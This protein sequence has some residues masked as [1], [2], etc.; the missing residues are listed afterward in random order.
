MAQPRTTTEQ[1]ALLFLQNV[2]PDTGYY[3]YRYTAGSSMCVGWANSIQELYEKMMLVDKGDVYFSTA[4]F[5]DNSSSKQENVLLLKSFRLDI[6]IGKH[7]CY[8]SIREG[9]EALLQFCK[10]INIPFPFLVMSGIGFHAWWALSEPISRERWRTITDRLK[11]ACEAEGLL[12]D[13]VVTKDAARILRC[14]GTFNCKNGKEVELHS[15]YST[16]MKTHKL[17]SFMPLITY[18]LTKEKQEPPQ[19][20][21]VLF[22][23]E[24]HKYYSHLL[25]L[26]PNTIETT[27]DKWFQVAAAVHS[28]GW[29]ET[30]KE[31]FLAWS[32]INPKHEMATFNKTWNGLNNAEYDGK[33]ITPATLTFLAEKETIGTI[34]AFDTDDSVYRMEGYSDEKY[35]KYCKLYNDAIWETTSKGRIKDRSHLNTN[36]AVIGLGIRGKV[37][38]FKDKEELLV[39][40][41]SDEW[42]E[43]SDKLVS[44]INGIIQNRYAFEAGITQTRVALNELCYTFEYNPVREYLDSLVWD[45]VSRLDTWLATW[46]GAE[47]NDLNRFFGSTFLIAAV[48]RAKQPGCKFDHVLVLE[49]STNLGKS[50]SVKILAGHDDYFSD[51]S[52]INKQEREQHELVEGV[53]F[54]EIS[55]LAGLR[56]ADLEALKAF[57]TRTSDKTRKAYAHKK[58]ESSRTC[59]FI[60]TTDNPDPYLQDPSGNRRFW[61]VS[62]KF[63]DIKGLTDARDQ[64]FAE[65]VVREKEHGP[66]LVPKDLFESATELQKTRLVAPKYYDAFSEIAGDKLDIAVGGFRYISTKDIKDRVLM[67]DAKSLTMWIDRDIAISM[68]AHGWKAYSYYKDGKY[69]SRGWRR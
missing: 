60:G 25:S 9:I 14:P 64:L 43:F 7:N 23:A 42:Q 63:V 15:S 11:T 69:I 59:V 26:I 38:S 65:A 27:Y 12:V 67:L 30:G 6:D 52:I 50:L 37:N 49:G 61:P 58:T 54:Y 28:L 45:K 66:L 10:H 32:Q 1:E 47:D 5:I 17:T 56:K 4:S 34:K 36:K 41:L 57:V 20:V 8:G 3:S 18:K 62:V 29:G 2:L 44:R 31:M 68:R 35:D 24:T 39:P 48:R 40:D 53:W 46:Y 16:L 55:E 33:K 13:H 51:Q 22:N 19:N 21:E